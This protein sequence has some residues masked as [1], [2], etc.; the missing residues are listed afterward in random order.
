MTNDAKIN[1]YLEILTPHDH[2]FEAQLYSSR[3]K[4]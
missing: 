4:S 2:E 3:R 1:M